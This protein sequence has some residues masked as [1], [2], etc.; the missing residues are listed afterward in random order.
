ML[1]RMEFNSRL[2]YTVSF[3]EKSV[4]LGL[5]YI[6]DLGL[7]LMMRHRLTILYFFFPTLDDPRKPIWSIASVLS[8]K[9]LE[10]AQGLACSESFLVTGRNQRTV[11]FST[12]T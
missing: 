10:F 4:I 3:D 9:S 11:R 5:H 1:L 12:A 6:I 8:S 2:D 7:V